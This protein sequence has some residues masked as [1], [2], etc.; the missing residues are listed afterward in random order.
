MSFYG[1]P[2]PPIKKPDEISRVQPPVRRPLMPFATIRPIQKREV[3][4]P[5]VQPRLI[6]AKRGYHGIVTKPTNFL[7][8]EDGAEHVRITPL[9]KKKSIIDFDYGSSYKDFDFSGGML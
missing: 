2:Q 1:R 7:V 9:K 5:R 3:Q 8:G 4:Q 6:K